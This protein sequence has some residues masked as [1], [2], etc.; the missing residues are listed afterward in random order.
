M[1]KGNIFRMYKE[2]LQIRKRQ[3]NRKWAKD[4]NEHFTQQDIQMTNKHKWCVN[5]NI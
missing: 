1:Y 2:L 3:P 4:L 5:L